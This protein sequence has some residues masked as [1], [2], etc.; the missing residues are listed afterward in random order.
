MS[1]LMFGD[2]IRLF[3]DSIDEGHVVG[4]DVE[5]DS[6][7]EM[8]EVAYGSMDGEELSVERRVTLL[9]G[10]QLPTEEGDGGGTVR[11]NLLEG[12]ADGMVTGV[13]Q[14][15]ELGILRWEG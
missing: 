8:T 5:V 1:L 3:G 15:L 6:F 14:E 9:S 13:R 2:W 7:E 11:R 4:K 10:G 12:R